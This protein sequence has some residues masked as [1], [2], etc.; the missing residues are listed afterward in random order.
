MSKE[1]DNKIQSSRLPGFYKLSLD[2]RLD[3]VAKW[4][5]LDETEKAVLN[6]HG[7]APEQADLMI[8]NALGTFELPLGIATNFLINDKDYL[9]PMAVEEP[10]VVAAISHAAKLFRAGGGFHAVASDPIMIG[11]IQVL[12]IPDLDAAVAAIEANEQRLMEQA[13]LVDPIIIKFGGGAR[14]IVARPFPDTPVGPMLIVHLYF[15]T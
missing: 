8:E 1:K 5:G 11:Q 7:L 10:S 4:A 3:V 9:I 2:E 12:D 6:G 15:D 13:D 14:K